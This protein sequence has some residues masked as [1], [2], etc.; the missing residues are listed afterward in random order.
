VHTVSAQGDSNLKT[1]IK[2][3]N[4][5]ENAFCR[6]SLRTLRRTSAHNPQQKIR[7]K[8]SPTSTQQN[9]QFSVQISEICGE[10]GCNNVSEIEIQ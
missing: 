1:K 3:K 4:E 2:I 9:Y 5:N 7:L 6:N 8:Q 10:L